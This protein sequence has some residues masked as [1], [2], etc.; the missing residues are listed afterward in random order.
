MHESFVIMGGMEL[1]HGSDVIVKVPVLLPQQR[2][3]DF[4]FENRAGIYNMIL[5]MVLSRMIPYTEFLQHMKK[6]SYLKGNVSD[7]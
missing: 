1:Y 5:F 3:L 7:S 4:V 6:G 2:M